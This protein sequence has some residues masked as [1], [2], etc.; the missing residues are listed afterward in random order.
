MGLLKG[1]IPDQMVNFL[2]RA[3]NALDKSV[4][5]SLCYWT[6]KEAFHCFNH[7]I[8]SDQLYSIGVQGLSLDWITSFL[9]SMTQRVQVNV[10][11]QTI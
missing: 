2:T 6:Y 3:M 10:S 7:N 11:Y 1:E 4:K 5:L 9:L 8:L